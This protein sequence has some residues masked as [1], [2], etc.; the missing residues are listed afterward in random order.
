[1]VAVCVDKGMLGTMDEVGRGGINSLKLL[2]SLVVAVKV[3]GMFGV[4][5]SRLVLVGTLRVLNVLDDDDDVVDDII[6]VLVV[7]GGG[8]V[9]LVVGVVAAAAAAAG[10]DAT[11]IEEVG[12]VNG[13]IIFFLFFFLLDELLF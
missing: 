3:L 9:L 1:M 10:E 5:W 4:F 13:L 7:V 11:A 12:T 8:G 6:D 2:P